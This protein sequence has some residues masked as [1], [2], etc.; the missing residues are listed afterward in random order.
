M[1][2]ACAYSVSI[3]CGNFLVW[4]FCVIYAPTDH[5]PAV[6]LNYNVARLCPA[7]EAVILCNFLYFF[8][9]DRPIVPLVPSKTLFVACLLEREPGEG[10][11]VC[12]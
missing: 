7:V 6:F 9:H 12:E 1:N 8:A 10:K 11:S 4:T 5:C 3:C 2:F